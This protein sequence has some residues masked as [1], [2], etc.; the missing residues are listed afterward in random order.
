[1]KWRHV[2]LGTRCSWLH[3]NLKGFRNREHRIHSSG[4]YKNPP[5]KDEHRG[6]REYHEKRSGKPVSLDQS[7]RI[8]VAREFV[9]KMKALGYRVIVCSVG[10]K[11]LH[12][13]AELPERHAEVKREVGK[14]K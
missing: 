13:I 4:D 7:L 11:H 1:M 8:I 5:P 3:G 2:M 10:A 14:C 9:L 12:S 6:L